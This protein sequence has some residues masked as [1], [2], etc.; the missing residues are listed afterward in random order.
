MSTE[1]KEI[2]QRAAVLPATS[3]DIQAVTRQGIRQ[4]RQRYVA[5]GALAMAVGVFGWGT[6]SN[7]FT[8]DSAPR[9]VQPGAG[10]GFGAND[11]TSSHGS[12]AGKTLAVADSGEFRFSKVQVTEAEDGTG[13][14][15]VSWDVEWTGEGAPP[16]DIACVFSLLDAAGTELLTGSGLRVDS[17]DTAPQALVWTEGFESSGSLRVP[18]V[19]AADVDAADFSCEP[20]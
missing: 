18:G 15:V 9:E 17:I 4:R 12:S 8:E 16:A 14:A 20:L 13:E 19:L 5:S 2:L 7:L 1:I 3:V 6:V 11:S 10:G